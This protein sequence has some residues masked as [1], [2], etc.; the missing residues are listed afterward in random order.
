MVVA[1]PKVV[2]EV[3]RSM[4]AQV[5]R[6]GEVESVGRQGAAVVRWMGRVSGEAAAAVLALPVAQASQE[7]A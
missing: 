4:E 3:V 1:V 5:S 6:E 2:V 7:A